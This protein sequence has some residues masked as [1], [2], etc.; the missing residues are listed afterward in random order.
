MPRENPLVCRPRASTIPRWCADMVRFHASPSLTPV[1]ACVITNVSCRQSGIDRVLRNDTQLATSLFNVDPSART[2]LPSV[3]RYTPE[4]NRS[5]SFFLLRRANQT[6]DF[7]LLDIKINLLKR[8]TSPNRFEA[9]RT[10][11]NVGLMPQSTRTP[12]S[13]AQFIPGCFVSILLA[14]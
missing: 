3:G 2:T 8:F 5:A 4:S 7:S 13:T 11:S 6:D 14:R 1:N 12:D 9:P 10:E